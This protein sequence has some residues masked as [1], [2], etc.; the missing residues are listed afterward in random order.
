VAVCSWQKAVGKGQFAV[1]KK[2]FKFKNK[3]ALKFVEI[4]NLKPF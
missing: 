3:K 1:G 2:V 4:Q